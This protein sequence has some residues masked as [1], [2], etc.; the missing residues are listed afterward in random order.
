[1]KTIACVVIGLAVGVGCVFAGDAEVDWRKL[2]GTGDKVL[3]NRAY[4]FVENNPKLGN[5]LIYGDSISIGYTPTVRSEL[6]GK[7]NVYRLHKNGG[8]SAR[9]IAAMGE[10]QKVMGEHWSFTWDVI[11][12]NVGLHDLKY[13]NYD[14]VNG[15]QVRTPAEYQKNLREIIRYFKSVA[16]NAK[17]IFATTTAVPEKSRGRRAGDAVLFNK[18]ALE[19]LKDYPEIAVNDLYGLSKP[20]QEEWWASPGNV[21]FNKNGTTAQG[22]Q[23]AEEILSALSGGQKA[24]IENILFIISDDLKASVLGCYGDAL[25]HTPNIDRLAKRGVVFTHAYAQGV[26]CAP[27]RPS[28]MFGRYGRMNIDQKKHKSFPQTLKENGWYSGRVG[29]VFHMRVPG[30]I[31]EG[32]N[33]ED[34]PESWDERFNCM[35]KEEST[36]G[37]YQCLNQN[38]FTREIEGRQGARTKNRMYVAVVG[39]GDGSDQPD[40]KAAAKAI[41][42]L[43]EHKDDP[44]VLSVGFVRPHYPHVG[45]KGDFERYPIEK[46]EMPKR[47][48]NDWDD[49][50]KQG[51]AGATSAKNGLDKY[52]DNQ[53]RMWAAYYASVTF[54]D[55]QV[56]KVLDELDRL[57]LSETTAVIFTS[58]HGYHLGEH[59]F[60]QKN[61]LHEEVTRVPL[62]VS[63]PGCKAGVSSSLVELVDIYPT[64]MDLV[65][66]KIP[67]QCHGKSMMGIL[68][69]HTTSIRD[70]AFSYN[71]RGS[72]AQF[73]IRGD[74][75]AFMK[76][77]DGEELYDM[78]KDPG[79]FTNLA[80]KAEYASVVRRCR[81]VVAEKSKVMRSQEMPKR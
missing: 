78:E 34:Y 72:S 33:G 70:Y 49:I 40:H 23:V 63:A 6:V 71:A 56:G 67:E 75:W 13:T 16:P 79:Q 53:K 47:V 80:G 5:V 2:T 54:M 36:P 51:L 20:N 43:R 26:M 19:V 65:G 1:M 14:T 7:A 77:T 48:E 12:F 11:H 69:D 44:F 74:K 21:H 52:P 4:D 9:V 28:F 8:D 35:G 22:R 42:L 39:D 27:S 30:D 24:G 17:L 57:G 81:E 31:V 38:I 68:K 55:E 32:T 73:A 10:M 58:D 76:Y 37:M 61:N 66:E 15:V 64:V 3:K 45:R 29:K 62:I 60:W 59:E 41:D 18:A 46:I 25:V 50:P